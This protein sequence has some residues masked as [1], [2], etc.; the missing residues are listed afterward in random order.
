MTHG[1]D[2]KAET[3]RYLMLT[4]MLLNELQKQT[5]DT[6]RQTHQLQ[7]E[8]EQLQRQETQLRRQ[9]EQI[10]RLAVQE[11]ED[12]RERMLSRCASRFCVTRCTGEMGPLM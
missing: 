11:S 4:S 7:Q 3:V 8:T 6:Q 5:I 10:K 12:R 9:A 1:A 2:G